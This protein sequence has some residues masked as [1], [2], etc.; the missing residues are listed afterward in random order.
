[1][2]ELM[3]WIWGNGVFYILYLLLI[4]VALNTT[5]HIIKAPLKEKLN[6]WQYKYRLRKIRTENNKS[7]V[8]FSSP[9]MKHIYLLAKTTSKENSEQDVI[10]FVVITVLLFSFSFLMIFLKFN[11]A[12]FG[13]VIGLLIGS[14]P[15]MLLQIRL[16]KLR[17]LMGGEFLAIVQSL[18]QNY[19]AHHYD[20]YHALVA[21]QKGI[22]DKT[23]RKIVLK[24]ISDLQVSRN[25]EELRLSVKLFVYTAG[26][27]WAKRLGNIIIKSYLH[28]EN[29]L[30]TLLTLTSQIEGT[31]EMLEQ[32]KSNTLDSV[33]NGFLTIP[34]FIMSIGLGYFVSGP[35][36]W[37]QLQ[38][39]NQWTLSLFVIC[40][41]GVIFSVFIA[42]ML[43][44]PKNDI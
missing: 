4:I 27:S 23:L 36:D 12:F 13:L 40:L 30:K 33:F 28:N 44:R 24:L 38:F 37:V 3:H 39:G 9:F 21:T 29:V 19:N 17:F 1:M 32:E 11:D 6:Q 7:H 5:K 31:E 25:E 15:Y 42:M 16:R 20:M 18:T 43:K 35:Q 14:I 8:E 22:K 26:S 2:D 34:I 10:S 41:V